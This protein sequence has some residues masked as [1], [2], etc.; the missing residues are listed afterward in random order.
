MY[1]I[2]YLKYWIL[3]SINFW[4]EEKYSHAVQTV[5]VIS[6]MLTGF[7][8]VKILLNANQLQCCCFSRVKRTTDNRQ[9]Q[10]QHTCWP[11]GNH[12][13]HDVCEMCR[14]VGRQ[15]CTAGSNTLHQEIFQ[16]GKFMQK[17]Q[18]HFHPAEMRLGQTQTYCTSQTA[19]SSDS[20]ACKSPKDTRKP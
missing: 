8:G 5:R 17:Q 18:V 6:T 10:Q 4:H 12:S 13:S 2:L 1:L 19:Q 20:Q 3:C 11:V 14:L 9:Q 15:N 16:S 7:S